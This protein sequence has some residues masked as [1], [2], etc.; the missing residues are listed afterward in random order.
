MYFALKIM[1]NLTNFLQSQDLDD[2]CQKVWIS[3]EDQHEDAQEDPITNTTDDDYLLVFKS[4]RQ[5]SSEEKETEHCKPKK[6]K[7]LRSTSDEES[8]KSLKSSVQSSNNVREDEFD[9][10]GKY[11]ATQLR[12]MD[13]EKA[14]RVKL[15]IQGIVSEAR[16]S[17]L[18]PH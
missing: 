10:Y 11:I 4:E 1:L 9:I 14:I 3:Q 18:R 6:R 15:E 13:L 8:L 17:S 7:K 5:G 16:L 12:K 2:T